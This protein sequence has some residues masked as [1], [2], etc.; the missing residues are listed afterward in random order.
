MF[1]HR[2]ELRFTTRL[3]V[4]GSSPVMPRCSTRNEAGPLTLEADGLV[5]L[6]KVTTEGVGTSLRLE[7]TT[8]GEATVNRWLAEHESAGTNGGEPMA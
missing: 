1:F 3:P 7:P 8:A 6:S 5:K 2:R 4:P